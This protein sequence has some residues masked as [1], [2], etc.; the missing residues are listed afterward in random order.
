MKA[1]ERVPE[2]SEQPKPLPA[3]TNQ[4]REEVLTGWQEEIIALAEA[5]LT[6]DGEEDVLCQMTRRIIA[7]SEFV[8]DLTLV[9]S[10][11]PC[12]DIPISASA[13]YSVMK[14]I[15]EHARIAWWVAAGKPRYSRWG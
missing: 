9:A 15:E 6:I 11:D 1:K 8:Q 4:E 5:R 3:P 10:G 14:E 2:N 13:L 12:R 7:I